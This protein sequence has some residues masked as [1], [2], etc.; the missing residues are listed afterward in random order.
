MA[1]L[2]TA[3]CQSSWKVVLAVHCTALEWSWS[4]NTLRCP[5]FT[6]TSFLRHLSGIPSHRGHGR[7]KPSIER[8]GPGGSL[9]HLIDEAFECNQRGSERIDPK[10]TYQETKSLARW[11]AH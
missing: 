9:V 11:V 1:G 6:T 4:H 3:R 7:P 5:S 8:T 10:A 2:G